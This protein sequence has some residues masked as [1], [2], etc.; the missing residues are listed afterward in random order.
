MPGYSDFLDA[1]E[2]PRKR[3]VR[4]LANSIELALPGLGRE[5]KWNGP[6]FKAGEVNV[7]TFRLFPA[8]H[9]Q[10]ILHCGSR[11]L[12]QGTDL[13]FGVEGL[14]HRWADTTRCTIE[15]PSSRNMDRCIHAVSLWIEL[16][17]ERGL[18]SQQTPPARADGD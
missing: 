18:I 14:S 12:P 9:F 7:A 2:H 13:T 15:V 6:S 16:L 11:K 4:E 8:P 1:L 17:I 3:D 5:I 10:L